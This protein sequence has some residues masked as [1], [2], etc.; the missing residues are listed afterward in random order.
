MYFKKRW[1]IDELESDLPEHA[2]TYPATIACLNVIFKHTRQLEDFFDP[3]CDHQQGF[4]V[5]HLRQKALSKMVN[6]L[7][8]RGLT[9]NDVYV[10]YGAVSFASTSPGLVPPIN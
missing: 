1:G 4:C 5:Y 10:A 9:A 3:H 2:Y 7:I 8:P 6:S